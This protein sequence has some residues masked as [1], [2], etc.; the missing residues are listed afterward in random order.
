MTSL[1]IVT[2]KEHLLKSIGE[3]LRGFELDLHPEKVQVGAYCV[4]PIAKGRTW[5]ITAL[6]F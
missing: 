3:R 4:K 6:H 1:C 2:A 5:S